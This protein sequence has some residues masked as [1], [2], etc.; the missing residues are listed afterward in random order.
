L[1]AVT[2]PESRG[3][4]KKFCRAIGR[5]GITEFNYRYANEQEAHVFA[6]IQLSEGDEER[7]AIIQNLRA[8]GYAVLD[9]TD[10][11]MAKMHVRHMVGGRSINAANELL[12]RFEFPERPGALLNFL[13]TI[14]QEWNI[15]LFH[16]RNHG[17][18]YGRVLVGLQ[19]PEKDQARFQNSLDSLGYRYW[20]ES[21]N[22]VYPMFLGR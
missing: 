16:Y 2:I 8:K 1:F 17:A 10:N 9:M 7:E 20:E 6:G 18:A 4:F 19:V 5:R 22:P 21:A 12:Y 15:S 13:N 11:E 3:S 14:G